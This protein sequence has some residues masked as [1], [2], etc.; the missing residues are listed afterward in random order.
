M[1]ALSAADFFKQPTANRP[2][3]KLLILKKYKGGEAFEM[4]D[5]T[6]VVFKFEKG[7]YDKIA[8]LTP[9]RKNEYS[10]IILKDNKGKSYKLT[11]LK[12]NKECMY[13]INIKG[14]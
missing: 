9:D 12:K 8:G 11:Q 4:A 6:H 1:A 3:R 13:V 2:D 5:N 10:S 7:V 14:E